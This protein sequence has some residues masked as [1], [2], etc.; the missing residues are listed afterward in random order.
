MAGYC[1]NWNKKEIN[2]S[3][4]HDIVI[5]DFSMSWNLGMGQTFAIDESI[6][7]AG[8][9]HS[10]QGLE[11]DY[12]GVI[13]GKNLEFI[14]GK[15]CANFNNHG[16]ADPSFKG[17][18]KRIKENPL[19]AQKEIDELIKSAY[20]VLLTRGIKGCY[21]YCEDETYRKYLKKIV[22]NINFN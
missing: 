3:D 11:F 12:V 13:I 14:D 18:K 2:N 16:D 19:E 6:N 17:I 5:D 15:V 4:F 21:V 20:R 7:E 1:W 9:I 8:C 10:V 22:K